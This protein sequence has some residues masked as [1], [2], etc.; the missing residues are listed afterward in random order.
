MFEGLASGG[1]DEALRHALDERLVA[2]G[3]AGDALSKVFSAVGSEWDAHG[4]C[5]GGSKKG[6]TGYSL[7]HRKMLL[8][9]VSRI[10]AEVKGTSQGPGPDSMLASFL[11]EVEGV[12]VEKLSE[13]LGGFEL[14]HDLVERHLTVRHVR[15]SRHLARARITSFGMRGSMRPQRHTHT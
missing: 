6:E 12:F 7:E 11:E 10:A 15:V 5:D 1:G 2:M 3:V 8:R 9:L 13:A 14:P 4:G